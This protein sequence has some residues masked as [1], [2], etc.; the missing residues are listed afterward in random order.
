MP[1]KK[2]QPSE[3]VRPFELRWVDSVDL[4]RILKIGRTTHYNWETKKNLLVASDF[5][6]KKYYDLVEIEKY[7]EAV[8]Q[9]SSGPASKVPK[10]PE[11][12][13]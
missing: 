4:R 1:K 2:Q 12:K 6:G 3:L 8:K 5:G 7:L 9:V 10:R 11:K 13:S